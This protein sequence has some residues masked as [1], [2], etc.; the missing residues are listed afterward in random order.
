[1][2]KNA[3]TGQYSYF[4]FAD[5][6]NLYSCSMGKVSRIFVNSYPGVLPTNLAISEWNGFSPVILFGI[7]N[8][9]IAL[10]ADGSLLKGYPHYLENYEFTSASFPKIKTVLDAKTG[11]STQRIL[12]N[13][14]SGGFIA[15]HSNQINDAFGSNVDL[16]SVSFDQIHW[17][18]AIGLLQWLYVNSRGNVVCAS[19]DSL[20]FNPFTW[21]GF[22]GGDSG[23]AN[24]G[25]I[26]GDDGSNQ[27]SAFAYPN[28]ARGE[29]IRI[30][31][32]NYIGNLKLNI[33]NV[34]GTCIY[35][36]SLQAVSGE[37]QDF[38][39]DVSDFSSGVYI[40]VVQDSHATKRIKFAVE[41]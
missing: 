32:L 11:V 10:E 38:Q 31:S 39:I 24:L 1:M 18:S 3:I 9:I 7:G 37:S 28:P 12:L 26:E 34:G 6:G 27:F 15:F 13:A 19:W 25:F 16:S 22:R 17:D 5:T 8:R 4:V 20:S 14:A 40:A 41:K 30:K 35:Q 2:I 29:I 36:S 21:N 23:F 33:Y